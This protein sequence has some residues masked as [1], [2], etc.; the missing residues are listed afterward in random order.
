M[1]LNRNARANQVSTRARE[2]NTEQ[3][4]LDTLLRPDRRLLP[5]GDCWKPLLST[6]IFDFMVKIW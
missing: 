2:I 6:A 4:L 3:K 5:L 1:A